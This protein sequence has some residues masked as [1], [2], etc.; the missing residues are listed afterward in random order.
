MDNL[1]GWVIP[2]IIIA[3][4]VILLLI[5]LGVVAGKRRRAAQQEADRK[6]AAELREQA[7]REKVDV[8]ERELK[9]RESSLQADK[10]RLEAERQ[11]QAARDQEREAQEAR[12]G[13]DGRLREAD[14]LDPE[15]ARDRHD[16]A[17]AGAAAGA[18]TVAPGRDRDHDGVA[19]RDENRGQHEAG[20]H[21]DHEVHT[22]GA[23]HS[24]EPA[25]HGDRG[26]VAPAPGEDASPGRHAARVD[27]LGDGTVRDDIPAEGRR[28]EDPRDGRRE[29]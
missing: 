13:L 4:I 24:D 9:A 12:E 26:H 28:A 27:E 14:E 16:G 8:Q 21:R 6:R 15:G 5:I 11:Q 3:V 7:E 22:F 23:A 2:A 19:D 25:V 29:I 1:P 17:G 18:G 10:A 20:E